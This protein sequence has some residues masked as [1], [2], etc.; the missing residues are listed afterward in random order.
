MMYGKPEPRTGKIHGSACLPSCNST[1]RGTHLSQ[2]ALRVHRPAYRLQAR[3]TLRARLWLSILIVAL[4]LLPVPLLAQ[5]PIVHVVQPGE[6]LWTIA[7]KYGTT[8]WKIAAANGISNIHYIY[9]G[10]TLRI[11]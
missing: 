8:P 2:N 10:Q 7:L 9:A 11:P 6:S 3:C 4:T 1:I 5:A